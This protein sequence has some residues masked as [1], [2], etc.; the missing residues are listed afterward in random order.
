MLSCFIGTTVGYIEYGIKQETKIQECVKHNHT[1]YKIEA[2]LII[3]NMV[4]VKN[5]FK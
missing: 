3:K 1:W 5:F 2:T 4:M